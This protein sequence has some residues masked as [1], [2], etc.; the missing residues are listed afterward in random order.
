MDFFK[1]I[2]EKNSSSLIAKSYNNFQ[3]IMQPN[4]LKNEYKMKRN[5]EG[6]FS[7]SIKKLPNVKL[8]NE[9]SNANFNVCHK[10]SKDNQNSL[11][12]PKISYAKIL[13]CVI[14]NDRPFIHFYNQ[15]ELIKQI[16]QR[17]ILIK[18]KGT[19]SSNLEIFRRS[20]NRVKKTK[21]ISQQNFS[22][23]EVEIDILRKSLYGKNRRIKQKEIIIP[24]RNNQNIGIPTRTTRQYFFQ[25]SENSIKKAYNK[26]LHENSN[27]KL[28][29]LI[30]FIENTNNELIWRKQSQIK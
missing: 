15:K 27:E 21:S 3:T 22:T 18:N 14:S 4:C 11:K 30:Y 9:K 1:S 25:K 26:M 2:Y 20:K 5:D 10:T 23:L 6:C 13:N 8:K 7:Y 24:K 17:P 29:K 12:L 19:I 28:D 16:L